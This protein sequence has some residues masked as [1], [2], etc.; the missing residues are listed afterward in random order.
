M[1]IGILIT[2]IR[3]EEKLLIQ[4][5]Q[6]HGLTPDLILDRD[7]QIDITAGAS[8]L[9]P[10]GIAWGGYDLILERCVSTSRGLY[11]L[12]ILNAWGIHTL[13]SHH[14]ALICSDKLRTTLALAQ[15]NIPQPQ[16]RVAFTPESA[17][18]T[19]DAIGYPAVLKPT[20]GSWGRL[21]ARVND[22]ETAESII[23]HRQTLGDYTHHTYYAQAYVNKP[24]RDIRAFVLGDRTLCAIYRHAEHWI[25]NTARG[26]TASNC[27][28]T[29]DIDAICRQTAQAV[30]GGIL[31]IDLLE[32]PEDGLLINEVNHTMEF[33]NSSTPTGINIPSEVVQ[34]ALSTINQGVLS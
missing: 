30:G 25:T 24:Q 26:G 12:A 28:I 15:F 13:N 34:Y 10:S 3:A 16:T 31:A 22:R 5:F 33:R 14:T 9:A 32:S 27:P 18:E 11:L 4:A 8:Q 29:S 19:I 1:R 7:V 23:E 2:H 6:D 21:L 17:I 20:T